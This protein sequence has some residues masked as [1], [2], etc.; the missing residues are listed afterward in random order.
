MCA[1]LYCGE[2]KNCSKIINLKNGLTV[3][4]TKI[5][6]NHHNNADKSFWEN[7]SNMHVKKATKI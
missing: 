2:Y 7:L 1:I 4:K 6:K 5:N 3:L